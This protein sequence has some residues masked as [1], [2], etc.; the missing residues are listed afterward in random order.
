VLT[1]IDINGLVDSAVHGK[2]GLPITIQVERCH[3]NTA[4]DRLLPDGSLHG[5][6]VPDDFSR[7]TYVDGNQLHDD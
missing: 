5:S 1:G 7:K 6:A 2:I 3:M 4:L